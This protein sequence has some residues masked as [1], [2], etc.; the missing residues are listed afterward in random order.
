MSKKTISI[1]TVG[2]TFAIKH[3]SRNS[4]CVWNIKEI[5]FFAR[6]RIFLSSC[7]S[8]GTIVSVESFGIGGVTDR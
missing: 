7:A 6:Y 8:M 4:L 3:R 5:Y 1:K 2:I